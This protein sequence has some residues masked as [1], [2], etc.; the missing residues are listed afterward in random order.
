MVKNRK[1]SREE[2][3]YKVLNEAKADIGL[4]VIGGKLGDIAI[5]SNHKGTVT[6]EVFASQ[7]A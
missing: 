7:Q 5:F 6:F 1:V 2:L 4:N 3:V